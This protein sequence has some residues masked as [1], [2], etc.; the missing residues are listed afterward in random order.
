MRGVRRRLAWLL[1]AG[2][3]LAGGARL[4]ADERDLAAPISGDADRLVRAHEI[5]ARALRWLAERIQSDGSLQMTRA[6]SQPKLAAAA[7]TALAFMA[8]GHTA[9]ESEDGYG[10]RV[11]AVI[12]WLMTQAA[13][14]DCACSQVKGPHEKARFTDPAFTTSDMHTQGYVAWAMAMAYGMSFG[15]ENVDQRVRLARVTQAA[16]HQIELSQHSSGGW[17]Y[18]FT[19]EDGHEGSVTI[20]V[21][22]A[23]RSAKEAGLRVDAGVIELAV[24]YL[25][26]SQV[27]IDG[28]AKFGGF[29][30]RKGDTMT[31]FA[32]TA[33]AVSSLNQT[34]D[35]DSKYVDYGIEYMRQRDPLTNLSRDER[36]PWYGRFYA[37]QAYW[38]Y[39]DLRHFRTWYPELV[40]VSEAEQD[41]QD[42]RFTDQAF[43]DVYAT[44][45]AALSLGVPFGYLPSFQR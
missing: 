42:G 6:E 33:A 21:L 38:Q 25:R 23:L 40:K 7:L 37:T 5:S 27:R 10:A 3:L 16:I 1:A 41:P 34:G 19:P 28:D 43:G 35:Y 17:W 12:G 31:T 45:M 9:D 32:L 22:Q 13:I 30:Y 14:D 26:E 44:A 18:H 15:S 11:R 4:S 24:R 20:T 8:N 36:W 39:R 2:F 29:R